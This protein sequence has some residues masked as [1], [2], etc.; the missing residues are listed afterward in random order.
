MMN[1]RPSQNECVL[2]FQNCTVVL[3]HLFA[4]WLPMHEERQVS[5]LPPQHYSL[6]QRVTVA[7]Q[8]VSIPI[9][10]YDAAG[11]WVQVCRWH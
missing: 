10:A 5:T 4:V 8:Y 1:G 9:A 6:I 2:F 7:S 3:V 11:H